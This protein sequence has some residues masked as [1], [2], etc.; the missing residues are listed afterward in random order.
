MSRNNVRRLKELSKR[1]GLTVEQMGKLGIHDF[2]GQPGDAFSAAPKRV[3][4]A[5]IAQES[6]CDARKPH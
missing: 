6:Y 4:A 1:E 2:I 5:S 3:M